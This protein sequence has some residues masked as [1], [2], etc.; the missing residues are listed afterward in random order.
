MDTPDAPNA[1][2]P[3]DP[4]LR[5]KRHADRGSHDRADVHALLDE[6][7]VIDVVTLRAGIPIA[8]PTAFVRLG[9][10]VY[11]HGAAAN[12][13]L[14]ALASGAPFS[15]SVT[16]LEGLVFSRC[17]ARHSMNYRSAVL[18]G[19][20]RIV[21]EEAEQRAALDAL[22]ERVRP[23]RSREA[24]PPTAEELRATLV[25]A[26]EIESASF[27]SRV[28]GPNDTDEDRALPVWAGVVPLSLVR[29]AAIE[30]AG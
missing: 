1:T 6:A 11:V 25:V 24:R 8:I 20:A 5:V 13:A 16:L 19:A 26:V 4:V 23:G 12:G 30:A 18:L 27:K 28:G 7:L 10:S 14:R 22:L 2:Y 9:E 17:A 21:S 29:G 3:V 15:L